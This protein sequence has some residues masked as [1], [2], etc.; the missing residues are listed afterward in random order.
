MRRDPTNWINDKLEVCTLEGIGNALKVV[1]T[2]KKEELVVCYGGVIIDTQ[3]L[4]DMPTERQ[5]YTIQ[6][7]DELYLS[8]VPG[9][10]FGIGEFLNHSCNPTCGFAS[11]I[12]LV[13]IRELNP[14][15]LISVDYATCNSSFPSDMKCL[16]GSN[17]CRGVIRENDWQLE[18]LQSRL[19]EYYQPYLKRQLIR[20]G[21]ID[22]QSD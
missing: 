14:G 18:E 15:D 10:D 11:E 7:N 1:H 6:I 13:A 21:R 9:I 3:E 20:K 17:N 19:L 2:I 16:C 8:A 12:N 5:M 4:R 22:T